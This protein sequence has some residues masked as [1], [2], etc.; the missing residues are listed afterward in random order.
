MICHVKKY[1]SSTLVLSYGTRLRPKLGRFF[2]RLLMGKVGTFR[3]YPFNTV[4]LGD[5]KILAKTYQFPRSFS[6]V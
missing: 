4:G 3:A 2:D 6:F 1:R 5:R